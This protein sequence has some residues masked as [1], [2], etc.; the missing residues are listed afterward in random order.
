MRGIVRELQTL[1]QGDAPFDCGRAKPEHES[2]SAQ[3]SRPAFFAPN[4]PRP[5]PPAK[6]SEDFSDFNIAA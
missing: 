1:V 6:K 3:P 4:A 2:P 5:R